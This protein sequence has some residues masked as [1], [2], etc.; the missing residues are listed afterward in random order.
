[1][2]GRVL[3]VATSQERCP[4]SGRATGAWLG[5]IAAFAEV[6][7][8]AGHPWRL[9]SPRGGAVPLD[10]RSRGGLLRAAAARRFL[11]DPG[12]R[13]RLE[14]SE[15]LE[16][17]DASELAGVYVAGGHGA[18]WDLA[19]DAALARVVRAVWDASGV[20]AAV[21]HGVAALL[22]LRLQDGGF[23]VSG[24]GLTGFSNR[25]ERLLGR[26]QDVPFL[27]EDELR[28]RGARYRK[29]VLPFAPWVHVDGQL[30]TGQNP[31]STRPLAEV[32]LGLLERSAAGWAD[33]PGRRRRSAAD[34]AARGALERP[35][36]PQG[37]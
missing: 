12:R 18:A 13:R 3:I 20:V 11:S 29:A 15:P 14:D 7:E 16:G 32:V 8:R 28:R 23:L 24:R 19:G 21:C 1:M 26:T 35:A 30:A 31:A 34:A 4:S 9:A 2:A 33:A 5:E 10:P 25:E 27:L 6:L 17:V 22:E 37:A 36:D